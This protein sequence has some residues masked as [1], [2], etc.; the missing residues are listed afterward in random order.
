MHRL[1]W[2]SSLSIGLAL[3]VASPGQS[4]P[5]ARAAAPAEKP[6][7]DVKADAK[8]GKLIATF[9]KPGVDGVSVR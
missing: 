7:L 4:A 2:V 3:C 8:S 1:V 6:L 9:P 5:A